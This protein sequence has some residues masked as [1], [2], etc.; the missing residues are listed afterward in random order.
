MFFPKKVFCRAFQTAFRI[1]LP[2][3]PYREPEILSS[4]AELDKVLKKEDTNSVLIVTDKGIRNSGLVWPVE[5]SLQSSGISYV[6]Y[7][8]TLPNP[9]IH[10]VE[11]ALTMYRTYTCS[12]IIAIG[13]GSAMDCA[14]AVG[15]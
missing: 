4:C 5:K 3:L 15:A 12:A 14:K 2:I 1:A 13:G 11:A 8:N 10:N 6:I 9:T 7:D